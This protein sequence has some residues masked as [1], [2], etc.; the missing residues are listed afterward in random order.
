MTVS[1]ILQSTHNSPIRAVGGKSKLAPNIVQASPVKVGE[2]REPFCYS[3]SISMA[4]IKN[5]VASRYWINDLNPVI[6][7]FWKVLQIDPSEMIAQLSA[8]FEKHGPGSLSLF[9]EKQVILKTEYARL[10]EC[11]K[12]G[13]LV[14]VRDQ[15]RLKI[16]VAFF[17][18]NR[19]AYAGGDQKCGYNHSYET[20]GRGMKMSMINRLWAFHELIS[21]N[22]KITLGDYEAVL[23]APGKDVFQIID[24]PYIGAGDSIYNNTFDEAAMS[25]LA[26]YVKSSKHN[27]FVTVDDSVENRER[28][29]NCNLFVHGYTSNAATKKKKTTQ[30]LG[31]NYLNANT[32][33]E[34]AS[35]A[36]PIKGAPP[37]DKPTPPKTTVKKATNDN[38]SEKSKAKKHYYGQAVERNCE[39]YT[40]QC[41]LEALYI[42]NDNR[43]FDL[44]PCSPRKDETAPV[45]AKKY[46]T[47]KDDGLSKRWNGIV[48][49]N[50]EYLNL[51]KWVEK[52]ADAVWCKSMGNAPTESSG[53]RRKPQ[54][55]TVIGLFPCRF[56]AQY[57]SKYVGKHAKVFQIDKRMRFEHFDKDGNLVPF[58]D[59]LPEPMVLAIWGNHEK[60]TKYLH[61]NPTINGYTFHDRSHPTI[62]NLPVEYWKRIERQKRAKEFSGERD[63]ETDVIHH[64]SCADMKHL[65]NNSIGLTVTSV[66]YNVGIDYGD[67]QDDLDWG[68]YWDEKRQI[69][70]EL[71]RVTEDGGR[72]ALNVAETA[73]K[74]NYPLAHKWTNLMLEAG[75]KSFGRI[76]WIKD[77]VKRQSTGWGSYRRASA[78]S[79]RE[80]HEPILLF[81]KG[82]EFKRSKYSSIESCSRDTFLSATISNWFLRP[83]IRKDDGHPVPFRVDLPARL[84]EFLSGPDDVIL[85]PFMGSGT[86]GIAALAHGRKFVG[87]E[88]NETFAIDARE[89]IA[90]ADAEIADLKI[91]GVIPDPNSFWVGMSS[92]TIKGIKLP[93]PSV[94]AYSQHLAYP[95]YQSS[96]AYSNF[97]DFS[98]RSVLD[99]N[100]K[101][102]CEKSHSEAA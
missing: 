14:D 58:K 64:H 59:K 68:A 99:D 39:A 86:T 24:P 12:H 52:A 69:A 73:G 13:E 82:D 56:D 25:K 29:D 15:D 22:V 66:P 72:V 74:R 102:E 26:E 27:C 18:V 6:I 94:N 31:V 87:Y 96:S 21:E 95:V 44:D 28:F 33:H 20:D 48:F 46:F 98:G 55:E 61:E 76:N 36:T 34:L 85:D 101:T 53:K 60:F 30:L 100:A 54:A 70:E 5:G 16:A 42:A 23:T 11:A 45:K 7:N 77:G 40:P 49:M 93:I 90:N 78:P 97:K 80:E 37:P 81:Y 1:A 9:E 92:D 2:W 17:V 35:I 84:I 63:F 83:E 8:I 3:A 4:A 41:F 10:A 71:F 65:P 32:F 51:N 89:R 62:P 75:F 47:R 91:N 79:I 19:L 50:P 57:W 67:V 88:L 38:R 43:P